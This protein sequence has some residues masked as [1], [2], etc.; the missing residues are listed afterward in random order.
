MKADTTSVNIEAL[1]RYARQE[2]EQAMAMLQSWSGADQADSEVHFCAARVY[3]AVAQ[4]QDVE[5]AIAAEDARWRAYAAEQARKVSSA[6]KRRSGPCAGHSVIDHRWVSPEAFTL[7]AVHIR[8]MVALA[9][10]NIAS[11]TT[12]P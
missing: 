11:R 5:Q 8:Q 3:R 10:G 9:Q 1:H 12:E 4:G 6:P 7:K 2:G